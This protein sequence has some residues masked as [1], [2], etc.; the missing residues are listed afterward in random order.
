V[1]LVGSTQGLERFTFLCV[2]VVSIISG[3]SSPQRSTS[4]SYGVITGKLQACATGK[5]L[6]PTAVLAFHGKPKVVGGILET[7][8]HQISREVIGRWGES[9][10]FDLPPG[11]YTVTTTDE[12]ELHEASRTWWGVVPLSVGAHSTWFVN[13][14]SRC[15]DLA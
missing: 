8:G 10:R 3:C 12:S 4:I 15:N 14:P 6:V 1:P 9:Y 11:T 5:S 13:L 7:V 2:L